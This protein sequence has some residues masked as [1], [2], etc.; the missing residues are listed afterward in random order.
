MRNL[1][2][3]ADCSAMV[4]LIYAKDCYYSDGIVSMLTV[5]QWFFW[6]VKKSQSERDNCLNADCSAMVFLIYSFQ[7]ENLPLIC[8]NADCSAMVF[9]IETNY[10]SYFVLEV[11]ML[12][13]LQWFFWWI[14]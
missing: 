4:F 11:S 13:V 6:Y 12:T 5:L 7:I 3:N 1:S 8:L 2:L 14:N 9:L 10:N